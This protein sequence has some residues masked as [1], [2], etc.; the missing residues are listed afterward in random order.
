[1]TMFE[2]SKGSKNQSPSM[3]YDA[4][5]SLHNMPQLILNKV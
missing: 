2:E 3:I 5:P 4:K 1:M